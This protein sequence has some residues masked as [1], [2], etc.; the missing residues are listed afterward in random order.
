MSKG[1]TYTRSEFVDEFGA[2]IHKEIKGTG[3][4]AGTLIAQAI[5]E[6]SGKDSSGNWK[7]G[8]SKLS[9]EAKNYFGIKASN[10]WKGKI[11]NI[12]TGEVYN[13]KEVVVNANF[14]AYNSVKDS[15][16]DYVK[17]LQ[18]NGRYAK[19][20]VFKAKTVEEQAK[21]LKQAGYATA[22]A[23]A[24]TVN[25]V[26][27]SVKDKVDNSYKKYK[28]VKTAKLIGLSVF[29]IVLVPTIAY[30]YQNKRK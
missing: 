22:S 6:S 12:D 19:A 13:G 21:R 10:G 14:R 20:G 9:R 8:G 11:Y 2:F 15:I 29:L 24:D 17:F 4:L 23:Y 26:Y 1:K 5:L 27:L 7:V 28:Q 30:L 18:E 16:R 25:K 3:I